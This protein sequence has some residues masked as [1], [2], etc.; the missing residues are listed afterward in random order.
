MEAYKFS[1]EKVLEWR[2]DKEKDKA[3]ELA[4]I[5]RRLHEE[6]EKLE[7]LLNRLSQAKREIQSYKNIQKLQQQRL[8]IDQ[9]E[10]EIERKKIEIEEITKRFDK[11]REELLAAQ[12]DRKVMEK[13]KEKD[14]Q[15]YKT[16]IQK[17]EQKQLD[18]AAILRYRQ[19]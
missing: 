2:T 10:E 17:K 19:A 1:L 3:R 9:I 7:G 16:Q 14:F 13:L 4:I 15:S 5:Q 11:S 12:K 6:E 18:E 8:Y